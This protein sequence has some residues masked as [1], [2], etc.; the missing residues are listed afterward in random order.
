MRQFI[1]NPKEL[2]RLD[3]DQIFAT[4]KDLHGCPIPAVPTEQKDLT[5]TQA[6]IDRNKKRHAKLSRWMNVCSMNDPEKIE[7]AKEVAK[8]GICRDCNNPDCRYCNVR[9]NCEGF[10]KE[11]GDILEEWSKE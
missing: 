7:E 6:N 2:N 11:V 9:S 8:Q 3:R 1:T 10:K 5:G 4:G